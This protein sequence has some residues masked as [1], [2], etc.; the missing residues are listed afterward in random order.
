MSEQAPLRLGIKESLHFCHLRGA[1][2]GSFQERHPVM[3]KPQRFRWRRRP[4]HDSDDGHGLTAF[5]YAAQDKP[6]GNVIP[7][8]FPALI[9]SLRKT[10]DGKIQ[11][12]APLAL[13]PV[14]NL[15]AGKT[16]P[17]R[18]HNSLATQG[19]H[20]TARFEDPAPELKGGAHGEKGEEKG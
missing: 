8:Q 20:F 15:V 7:D 5:H 6:R 9:G 2:Q 19:N 3:P 18:T 12:H 1:M 4:C 11:K 13:P 16:C 17:D 14:Q 10:G